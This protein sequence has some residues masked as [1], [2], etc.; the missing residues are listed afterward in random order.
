M[1]IDIQEHNRTGQAIG[2]IDSDPTGVTDLPNAGQVLE[3]ASV[4][5]STGKGPLRTYRPRPLRPRRNAKEL[6]VTLG[7][8]QEIAPVA[9]VTTQT[10]M[11]QFG[12]RDYYVAWS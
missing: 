5:Q 10:R 8:T 7:L 2:C 6:P 12:H 3:E 1:I 4:R 11:C 9:S